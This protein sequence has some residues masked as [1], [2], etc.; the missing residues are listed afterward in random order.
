[1]FNEK[2]SVSFSN[3]DFFISLKN[4][5]FGHL[6]FPS[7]EKKNNP[8]YNKHFAVKNVGF[9]AAPHFTRSAGAAPLYLDECLRKN[10]L[11]SFFSSCEGPGSHPLSTEGRSKTHSA[12]CSYHGCCCGCPVLGTRHPPGNGHPAKAPPLSIK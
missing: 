6:F 8:V 3:I 11:L 5:L 4:T 2:L 9:A 10:S 12:P 7:G 1:M